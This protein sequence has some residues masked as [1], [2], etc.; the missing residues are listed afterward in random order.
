MVSRILVCYCHALCVIGNK[1]SLVI[2]SPTDISGLL[3]LTVWTAAQC[4][5][6]TRTR[7]ADLIL[8]R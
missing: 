1:I 5:V 2:M 3:S 7:G 4:Y 8:H 6:L